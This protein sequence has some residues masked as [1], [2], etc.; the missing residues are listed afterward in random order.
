[1]IMKKFKLLLIFLLLPLFTNGLL[2]QNLNQYIRLVLTS[3]SYYNVGATLSES[4]NLVL[5]NNSSYSIGLKKF[6]VYKSLNEAPFYKVDGVGDGFQIYPNSNN[7]YTPSYTHQSS[8][9]YLQMGEWFVEVVYTNINDYKQYTKKFKKKANTF[10]TNM[11]LEEISEG[12]SN[13]DEQTYVINGHE[14]VDLGLPSGKLW[15]KT[16]YGASSEGDY[17][18]Y[19]DWSSR[20]IIQKGWGN[21]WFT[22]SRIDILELY[23]QCTFTWGYNA[24]SVYGCKVTG[25]NG[26]SIF[27]PAAGFK[28]SGTPQM[29]GSDIYY[30]SDNE[31]EPGFAYALQGS[32]GNGIS[33]NQSWNINYAAFPIR[34]IANK[35]SEGDTHSF[36]DLALPSGLLW[37]SANLGAQRP[38]EPGNY[39]AWGETTPNKSVYDATTYTDPNVSIISG[40]EY[41]AAYTTSGGKCRIPTYNEFIELINYCTWEYTQ[42]NSINGYKVI[43]ANGNS[44]FLPFVGGKE[45]SYNVGYSPYGY[46]GQGFYV[47]GT[48]FQYDSNYNWYLYMDTDPRYGMYGYNKTRGQTI[49]PVQ[50]LSSH[51]DG[52]INGNTATSTN[53]YSLDGRLVRRNANLKE[54]I[55]NLPSGIY[56]A[57]GKKFIVK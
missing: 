25:P 9:P 50:N 4:V 1:M 48:A 24:N 45:D 28:I 40:T 23:N 37:A 41:D 20:N 42:V 46:S 43:G 52:I 55:K 47:S 10:S 27:L 36:V 21:E 19:M 34:P 57:N 12:G 38:E 33:V 6:Y 44:I 5:Y 54:T 3:H 2:A 17:G 22:P 49:R 8:S 26:K 29:V 30:W 39:Y 14:Y 11:E 13:P 15:A 51:I 53:I 56:I 16:N 7:T 35:S 32:A 18:I 31:S